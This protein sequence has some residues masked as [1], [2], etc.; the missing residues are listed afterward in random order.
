MYYRI[1]FHKL[2]IIDLELEQYSFED[3]SKGNKPII[4]KNFKER[5]DLDNIQKNVFEHMEILKPII[6]QQF[7]LFT[8]SFH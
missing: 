2:I 3:E 7:V 6:S 1:H 5:I 4:T 8:Q